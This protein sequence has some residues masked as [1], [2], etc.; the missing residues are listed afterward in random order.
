MFFVLA[1]EDGDSNPS[2]HRIFSS[3]EKALEY[4]KGYQFHS[5]GK[6]NQIITHQYDLHDSR[7]YMYDPLLLGKAEEGGEIVYYRG[8]SNEEYLSCSKGDMNEKEISSI[9]SL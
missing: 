9:R 4:A 3:E 1:I 8:L 5:N 7:M 2:A 6:E